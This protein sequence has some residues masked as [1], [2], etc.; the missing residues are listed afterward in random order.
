MP[1]IDVIP[2]ASRRAE[3]LM[4]SQFG[5]LTRRTIRTDA[6]AIE[7]NPKNGISTYQIE[8]KIRRYINFC[9]K[10]AQNLESKRRN[11]VNPTIIPK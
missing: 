5:F 7:I 3:I 9:K 4:I 8:I 11:A 6:N 1:K 10:L 2:T